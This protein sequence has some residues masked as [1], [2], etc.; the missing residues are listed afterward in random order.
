VLVPATIYTYVV[1]KRYPMP[2]IAGGSPGAPNRLVVRA[3]GPEPF[4]VGDVAQYIRHEAGECYEYHY[5]GGGGWG[6]PLRRPPARVLDDVLDEYV[7]IE[8]AE[9]EY[10]V[11]LSGALDDLSLAVDDAATARLRAEKRAA[12]SSVTGAPSRT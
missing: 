9:R 10:G 5:G 1:G 2:G 8:A 3:G 6:D 4:E 12:R 7:S 11:V